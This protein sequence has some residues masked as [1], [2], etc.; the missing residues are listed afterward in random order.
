MQDPGFWPCIRQ[1][2]RTFPNIS[3]GLAG[4][5]P[6]EQFINISHHPKEF[7]DT[8]RAWVESRDGL[9]D[10]LW[11]DFEPSWQGTGLLAP[12]A[13][14]LVSENLLPSRLG[15]IQSSAW[16]RNGVIQHFLKIEF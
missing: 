13:S 6:D 16:K 3:I 2:K 8:V 15:L 14:D 5:G 1:I 11:T 12:N 9:I 4:G 7:G 10:E